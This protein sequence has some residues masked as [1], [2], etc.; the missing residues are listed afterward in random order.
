MA[1]T[2]S[3]INLP[4]EKVI[5]LILLDPSSVNTNVTALS[6]KLMQLEEHG[7]NLEFVAMRRSPDG[8]YSEDVDSYLSYLLIYDYISERSSIRLTEKGRKFLKEIVRKANEKYPE[9]LKQV[10]KILNIDLKKII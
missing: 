5:A 7:L 6:Q 4:I 2:V 3:S 1:V 9:A 10:A 8:F